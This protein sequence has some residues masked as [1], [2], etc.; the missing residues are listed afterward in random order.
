MDDLMR[1]IE[2]REATVAVIGLG[3]VGLPLAI[4][5]ARAGFEVVGYDSNPTKAGDLAAGRSTVS[6]VADADVAHAVSSGRFVPSS[7]AGVLNRADVFLICVPTPLKHELP[8]LSFIE[9]AATEIS[10][11][12]RRG[13]LVVL[14][15]TTYPGTTDD[16]LRGILETNGLSAGEDF[17]LG[18]SPE[19]IDPGN[20]QYGLRNV[21]KVIGGLDERSTTLMEVFYGSFISKTV[22]VS[23]PRAA[24]MTKL[25][26]NTYRHINIA[27][28]NEMAIL[29]HDLEI[30]IWEVID[31]AATK[32]FGFHA[33][34]PG[35]GWGGHCIPVD[36]AYLSWRV[37]QMGATA[38]FVDL[39]R[40]IN[41]RMPGYVVDRIAHILNDDGKSVRSSKIL[42][43]GMT[44]KA[45][46]ADLRESPALQ[47][48]HRLL[49]AGADVVVNDPSIVDD[50][51]I[52]QWSLA[53]T[54][55][56]DDVISSADLVVVLTPHSTY[57]WGW[58]CR[59]ATKIF[60]TRNVLRGQEGNITYL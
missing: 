22:R 6:D 11:R 46:V 19:R 14:E 17:F 55:L 36:P 1:R 20:E 45:D 7:D 57:D 21:P 12:M 9:S 25:M 28:A 4:E 52:G 35:P 10:R 56:T 49:K 59:R 40:Q 48:V 31:A 53:S 60:D 13:T 16:M 50:L 26:E 47:V 27:L 8:D 54:E 32:P 34:Y 44:Y 18:F 38:H 58:I 29:A 42:A 33:F 2:T 23:S 39:A 51:V 3:Y 43:L 24:E 37:R 30:D 41:D 5:A 15:S